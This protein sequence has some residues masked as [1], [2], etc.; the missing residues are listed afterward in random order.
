MATAHQKFTK[1]AAFV[2]ATEALRD[3]AT[4]MEDE[5]GFA[6]AAGFGPVEEA[7]QSYC[8]DPNEATRAELMRVMAEFRA[9]RRAKALARWRGRIAQDSTH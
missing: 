4:V 9:V 8:R 2:L 3:A 6:F 7:M 1:E 5:V